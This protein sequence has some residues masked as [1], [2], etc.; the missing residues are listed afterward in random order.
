MIL[1]Y[2]R[3]IWTFIRL[4]ALNELQYRANF[5]MQ[6]FSSL[7][8]LANGLIGLAL[9][10]YHTETLAGWEP[11]ELLVVVG[12]YTLIGGLIRALIQP[13]MRNIMDG[14]H[15]GTLDFT[16]TKPEDSQLLVSMSSFELWKLVDVIIGIAVLGYAVIKLGA[17]VGIEEAL[18]FT[19]VLSCGG[20]MVYSLWLAITTTS[21]WVVRV[22][23][24]FDLFENMYQ[25]GRWPVGIYPSWLRL[26]LT[27][28]V[29]VAFAVTAP[30]EALTARLNTQTLLLAMFVAALTLVASRMFWKYGLR[31]YTGAS[32]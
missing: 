7:L 23:S 3:L 21:F 27:F 31:N 8:A 12:V 24:L 1:R 18:I 4:S 26:I 16:L 13:N 20:L 5:F 11:M 2:L 14:V 19:L 25:A 22:H 9:V 15:E 6:F 28:L 32:A 30:A 10:F 17:K 29:P